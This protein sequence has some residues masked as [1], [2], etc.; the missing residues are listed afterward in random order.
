MTLFA[1]LQ[2]LLAD[3]QAAFP[4]LS[5]GMDIT[6]HV[7]AEDWQELARLDPDHVEE[8]GYLEVNA[9]EITIGKPLIEDRQVTQQL[10]DEKAFTQSHSLAVMRS[11]MGE[12]SDSDHSLY[13]K[14]NEHGQDTEE[15]AEE[16]EVEI[17]VDSEEEGAE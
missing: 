6:F 15:A 9:F 1:L 3:A 12:P 10:I 7:S 14:Q 5:F 17:E 8:E 4:D 2:R 16:S 11:D 13:L